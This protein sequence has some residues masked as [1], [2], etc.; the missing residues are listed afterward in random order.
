[1]ARISS[2]EVKLAK[3]ANPEVPDIPRW[4][5]W[6]PFGDPKWPDW[7]PIGDHLDHPICHNAFIL[8]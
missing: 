6:H 4:R 5:D 8:A 2:P 7:D 3:M 1:M